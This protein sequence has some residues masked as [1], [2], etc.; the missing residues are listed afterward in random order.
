MRI[1]RRLLRY[2]MMTV[3]VV[4]V[5]ILLGI[6]YTQTGWF[7]DWLR[8]YIVRE[9]AQYLNGELRIGQLSGSLFYGIRMSD[10]TLVQDGETVIALKDLRVDYSAFR[11]VASGIVLDEIELNQPV[12]RARRTGDGW[13]LMRLVKRQARERERTGPGRPITLPSI[14]IHDGRVRMDRGQETGKTVGQQIGQMGGQVPTQVTEIEDLDV[15]AAFAYQPVRFTVDIANVSFKSSSPNVALSALSGKVAVAGDDIH[16]DRLFIRLPETELKVNGLVRDYKKSRQLELQVD[17]SKTTFREVGVLLPVVRNMAPQP[18]FRIKTS[19]PLER[20]DADVDLQTRDAGTVRGKV[21][22]MMTAQPRRIVGDMNVA[23]LN[24]APWLNNQQWEGLINGRARFDLHLPDSKTGVK[25]GG[26]YHFVGPDAGAFGYAAQDLDA[27]GKFEG[28]R[29][30]IA[31]ARARAYGA[32]LTA[33][34]GLVDATETKGG[35]RY[36]FKGRASNVD[37]RRVPKQFSVPVLESRIDMDYDLAGRGKN[38]KATAL[39]HP[40]VVEGANISEGMRGHFEL[41][42]REISYGGEGHIEQMN[43]RR[44]GRALDIPTLD[45]DRFDSVIGGNFRV[46]VAG[47]SLDTLVLTADGVVA[48][49]TLLATKF[50]EMAFTTHIEGRKLEATAKGA[51]EGFN[52]TMLIDQQWLA[53]TLTGTVDGKVTLPDLRESVTLKT[54]EFDGQVNAKDSTLFDLSLASAFFDGRL[55]DGRVD[56]RQLTVDGP[57]VA[58]TAAGT[59]SLDDAPDTASTSTSDLT[60]RFTVPDLARLGKRLEQPF[61]GRAEL[62]GKLTGNLGVLETTGTAHLEPARYGETGQAAI[63]DATYKVRLPDLDVENVRVESHVDAST[64]TIP[65]GAAAPFAEVAKVEQPAATPQPAQSPAPAAQ[66]AQE[67]EE[68]QGAQPYTIEKLSADVTYE[69]RE[70]TFGGTAIDDGRTMEAKGRASLQDGRQEVRLASASLSAA[71]IT[72]RTRD[73]AEALIVHDGQTVAVTGLQI[74]NGAQQVTADGVV[75]VKAG[76]PSTLKIQAENVD[77]GQ[78]ALLASA[79]DPKMRPPDP[80]LAGRLSAN[81]RVTGTLQEPAVAGTFSVVDGAFREVKYQSFGGQVSYDQKRFGVDVKLEQSPGTA[82]TARGSLPLSLISGGAAAKA[83]GPEDVVDLQVQSTPIDLGLIQGLTTAVTDVTGQLQLDMRVKGRGRDVAFEG[84]V[85]VDQGAFTVASTGAQYTGLNTSLQF[86]PSRLVV[87]GLR[88]LDDGNDPLEVKG[89]LGLTGTRF[90]TLDLTASAKAFEL[91]HNEMGEAEVNLD[92]K[93]GGEITAPQ[94][95]G[96]VA[97]ERGRIEIDRLL[98]RLTAGAYATESEAFAP[99]AGLRESAVASVPTSKPVPNPTLPGQPGQPEPAQPPQAAE[100]VAKVAK[101]TGLSI[102]NRMRVDVRTSIPDN[103]ILR[104]KDLRIGNASMGLG[105]INVT[106]GGDLRVMRQPGTP[107]IVVGSVNTVRG[108]YDYRG[109]Q[110]EIMRDGRISFQGSRI[111]DPS[112]DVTAQRIIE[113]TGVDARIHIEGTAQRPQLRFS[114]NPPMD[115][116]DVIALIIFNRPLSD[117]ESGERGA[118]ADVAG[119]AVGGLIVSPLT[120]SIGRA[121]NLDVLEVGTTTTD[122]GGTGG[123][124]TVGKQVDD[125][126]FFRFRQ[127]FGSQEVSEFILEY[128]LARFLRI[129]ASAAEGEGVGRAQRSLTRRIERAGLDLIFYFSY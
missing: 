25:F 43:L 120:D 72:W 38:L 71:G 121:L 15:K 44:L 53:G 60:Y 23:R 35:I 87:D 90:G 13:N 54:F 91:L 70:L 28:G 24:L 94:V 27:R 42:N 1:L 6:G 114:S 75:G 96:T 103:L 108:S 41:Q 57:D 8:R 125:N 119:S 50:S 46:E 86:E 14:V 2:L 48:D 34:R 77:L 20:L 58:G 95:S 51:F 22:L 39:F 56:V 69:K 55:G 129:Q 32:N 16:I 104:G 113:P 100:D 12:I 68:S 99:A 67:S 3:A 111:N 18:S 79:V 52:P 93:I 29:L 115:E 49:S 118:I 17:S 65:P 89:V 117:L 122:T 107:T 123:T 37:M 4:M 19:G 88:I 26:T 9:A 64:I 126:L 47:R 98:R 5:V 82:L 59:M 62:G 40:S 31:Q 10:I 11:L 80:R 78:A 105:N 112:L 74:V 124:V 81:A 101:A 97:V 85:K 102:L 66:T 109:R 73:N 33:S 76:T 45:A 7:K 92:L 127:Q 21:T 116:S 106:V 61:A 63:V 83:P 36:E 30:E 84:F 110:F 128:Q